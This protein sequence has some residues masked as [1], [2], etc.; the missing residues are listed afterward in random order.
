[1]VGLLLLE[2]LELPELEPPELP[3][4]EP[5][6][7]P[8]LEPPELPEL[9]PPVSVFGAGGVARAIALETLLTVLA[10]CA[11]AFTV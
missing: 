9:E 6:E 10:G 4:L 2:L 8:E 1:M 5:P 11:T 7:L 3:E